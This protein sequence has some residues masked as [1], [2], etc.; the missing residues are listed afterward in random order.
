MEDG[1]LQLFERERVGM[2]VFLFAFLAPAAIPRKVSL[3]IASSVVAS[4]LLW[5]LSE[6][7]LVW[8]TAVRAST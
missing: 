1:L 3:S 4:F 8:I 6:L 7:S 2:P 5:S